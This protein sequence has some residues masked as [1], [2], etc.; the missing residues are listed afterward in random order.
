MRRSIS[1]LEFLFGDGYSVE[2]ARSV[3]ILYDF[4]DSNVSDDADDFFAYV[5]YVIALIII[6]EVECVSDL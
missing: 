2:V 6:N 3:Q 5:I 4:A 1:V